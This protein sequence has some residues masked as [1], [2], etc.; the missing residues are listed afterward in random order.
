MAQPTS[1]PKIE[2]L[3][4]R[5]KTDPKSRLFYPLAE[6][7][8]K[9]NQWD[10]SERV[11][12]AGLEHH[13]TYLSAWVSLG[14]VLRD[15]H[16]D[17]GA[18][19]ALKKAL[20]L[21]PGNVVAAR[22]LGDSYLTI[23]DKV[24]AIKKYKL[25]LALMPGDQE[26][27]SI[28]EGLDQDINPIVLA[29][30]SEDE[31]GPG[32]DNAE[33][34]SSAM[35]AVS[36]AEPSASP[37]SSEQSPFDEPGSLGG[38]QETTSSANVAESTPFAA[39]DHPMDETRPQLR[40]QHSEESPW[41]ETPVQHL[42]T[43]EKPFDPDGPMPRQSSSSTPAPAASLSTGD[44]EPMSAAHGES[45]FEEPSGYTSAARTV[46]HPSGMH[47]E[48]S[49]SAAI[50]SS[51]WSDPIPPLPPEASPWAEEPAAAGSSSPA[52]GD[53][54]NA[55]PDAA[56]VFASAGDEPIA[57]GDVTNTLTMADLY[58]GQGQPEQA[59]AIYE[60]ILERDP[61]NDSVRAKLAALA[62]AAPGAG[63]QVPD[64]RADKLGR[65][66]SKVGRREGGSV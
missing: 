54:Q 35:P 39:A 20:Q 11:L 21:D 38:A 36:H 42:P 55:V 7:L 49:P 37:M 45:P 8:R 33:A 50:E 44:E 24:E 12:H 59:R 47:V 4:F 23:G 31:P 13:P 9:I 66:L 6:E 5:I 48:E 58:V 46:E 63:A 57:D 26:I 52:W 61:A 16:K 32:S 62:P 60:R 22:L 28:I 19:E 56:N 43:V 29:T 64:Q 14:R 2:E 25:V 17:A 10:E 41:G 34:Y 27:E 65:W 53:E 1:N 30:V 3:R 15:Q 40:S 51:M 18:I